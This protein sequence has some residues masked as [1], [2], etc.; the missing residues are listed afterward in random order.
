[1]AP[2]GYNQFC[3]PLVNIYLDTN[4]WNALFDDGLNPD[5][6][7]PRLVATNKRLVLG[8]HVFYEL[9]RTLQSSRSG[10]PI[11][12]PALFEYLGRYLDANILCA[13]DQSEL[14]P[15][16]MLMLK[17]GPERVEYFYP[18][19]DYLKIVA[20]CRRLANGKQSEIALKFLSDQSEFAERT[21]KGIISFLDDRP[22]LKKN[23]LA[24]AAQDLEDWLRQ[25][26]ISVR[27][28][29]NLARHISLRFPEVPSREVTEYA[30]G[31]FNFPMKRFARGLVR[32]DLYLHWRYAQFGALP[33]D[34]VDDVYH[35]LNASYCDMYATAD[36]KQ[37]YARLLLTSNTQVSIWSRD[38]CVDDWLE[39]L[40]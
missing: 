9:A 28:H 24:I 18:P 7:L 27:G 4:V 2:S 16:E 40:I 22:L 19:E 37:K 36:P 39:S 33:K 20:E 3:E 30:V 14:L 38:N 10:A 34:L 21:R 25:E 6:F 31:L 1:M 8:L 17:E 32:A 29:S 15:A 11:R 23:L 12:G 13:K 26:S 5:L 35:V